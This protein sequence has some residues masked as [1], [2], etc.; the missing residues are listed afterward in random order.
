MKEIKVGEVWKDIE[1]FSN[2]QISNYGRVKSIPRPKTKGGLLKQR[3]SNCDYF[4]VYLIKEG[5]GHLLYVH[6]LVAQAFIPNPNNLLEVNH[7]DGNKKNNFIN[8]LEWIT[9]KDNVLHRF[10]TLKQ[11]PFRKYKKEHIDY[12][13]KE[14]RN[15]YA[16]LYYQKNKEKI[17]EY[18]R[19][20]RK[21]K[22]ERNERVYKKFE[23]VREE[24]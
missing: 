4:Q 1:D 9:R 19:Q 13:T 15:Q 7:K 21:H 2:Y 6:R 17:L 8:N 22:K 5:K 20:W 18:G 24:R 10:R 16:R 12:S 3:N 14:G 11:E 23:K